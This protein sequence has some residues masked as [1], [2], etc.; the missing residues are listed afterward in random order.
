M[1][2][3]LRKEIEPLGFHWKEDKKRR[4]GGYFEVEMPRTN[5]KWKAY[6]TKNHWIF[7]PEDKL[8]TIKHI[9]YSFPFAFG[10]WF[11]RTIQWED[12]RKEHKKFDFKSGAPLTLRKYD[13]I[14]DYLALKE[15][16]SR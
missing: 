5:A 6:I 1:F 4:F 12:G 10:I 7:T 2:I 8:P 14:E 11:H 3:V 15:K 13:I 16:L 9:H